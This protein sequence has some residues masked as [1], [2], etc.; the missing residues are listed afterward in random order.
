[1]ETSVQN[2]NLRNERTGVKLIIISL[3]C[4]L[5]LIPWLLI[6]N[7]IS[8]RNST[9]REAESEVYEKWGTTQ[10]VKGPA[11]K[12]YPQAAD[13]K[14]EDLSF[15]L[16]PETLDIVG[17]VRTRTLSR[18][19]YDFTVYDADITMKGVFL[20]P[21][22]IS[23]AQ[24][25][26]LAQRSSWSM[27]IDLSSLKGLTDN[28]AITV[29]GH[30]LTPQEVS[31]EGTRLLWNVDVAPLLKGDSI[32][33]E[34]HL[35]LRGSRSLDFTPMG[36]TT[37]V[38]LHSD[39]ATPSFGGDFLPTERTVTDDGFDA[40]WRV[41]A[42][43][44]SFSQIVPKGEWSEV[45]SCSFGVELR[46]PVDQ[47]QQNERAAKYAF[48]IVLLT[49]AVVFFVEVR[50]EHPIHPVQYLLIGIAIMLFYTLLLSFSEHLSFLVAYL[51]ASVMTVAMITLYMG[52]IMRDRKVGLLIG[53]LLA[54]L[55][56]FIYILLQIESYALLV[57]SV[58]LF[59][60]LGAA[61]AA[62]RKIDWY[63][64]SR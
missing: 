26:T 22:S 57:G 20:M 2:N 43:N 12:V 55:Y 34:I 35:P 54:V 19:I 32:A 52:A 47:Y 17:D 39:C 44:R 61:M 36:N 50:R 15:S 10:V 37:S 18:G 30:T 33:Y 45:R 51:I 5:L 14:K 48:L 62:S 24:R 64:N 28:P 53:G 9:Q 29:G 58:A 11:I 63:R 46:R 4:L 27:A 38:R 23:E 13:N 60:L 8:E 1:M 56:A 42:L 41:L 31:N 16:L 49:F 21:A 40:E 59:A 3:L 6:R 7:M 25:S